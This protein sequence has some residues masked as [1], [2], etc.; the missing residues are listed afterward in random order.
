MVIK[1]VAI[2]PGKATPA[3][4][5]PITDDLLQQVVQ[6][7][8]DA[9]QPEKIILFGSYAYGEPRVDSDV[10]L[11]V[12][13]NRLRSKRLVERDRAVAHIANPDWL[14]MDIMVRTPQEVARRLGLGDTFFQEIM[15]RGLVL[16][17]QSRSRR[18][19]GSSSRSRLRSRARSRQTA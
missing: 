15:T 3:W 5:T 12:I 6:R 1:S 11:L 13:M 2:S 8:V 18:R 7:I 16:Y 4:Y 10:D 9:F 19:M 17:E 14:A